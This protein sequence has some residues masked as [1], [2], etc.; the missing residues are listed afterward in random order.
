MRAGYTGNSPLDQSHFPWKSP[1]LHH[2]LRMPK[3]FTFFI[4]LTACVPAFAQAEEPAKTAAAE[5]PSV[6]ACIPKAVSD[7]GPPTTFP[8]KNGLVTAITASSDLAQAETLQGL[9]HL[10]GGWEFEASRHFAMAMK[11]DPL[12]LMAHWGMLL[13]I[14]T[15]NPE[16]DANRSAIIER[17]LQLVSDGEGTELERGYTYGIFKYL[18]EG[19]SGAAEAFRKVANKYPGELQAEIFAALFMRSGYDETG[20][21]TPEQALAEER[22]ATLVKQNPDNPIPLHALLLASAEAPD[23]RPKLPLAENLCELVPDYPP[24][25][26][27]LGHYQWR[28]GE[29]SKAAASFERAATLYAE[30]MKENNVPVADCDGWIRAEAYRAVA[31]ASKGDFENALATAEKIAKTPVDTT[32]PAATGSRQLVWEGKTLPARL[33]MYRGETGDAAKALASLPSTKEMQP[34]LGK[35]LSY[36]WVDGLRIALESQRLLDAQ[37]YAQAADT[38]NAMSVHGEAMTKKQNVSV[39]VGERSEWNR[40]FRSLEIL[41][42]VLRGRMALAGPAEGHGSAFNWFRAATDRQ[43]P[44]SMLTAPPILT[45]MATLL[46]DYYL[47]QNEPSKAVDAYLEALASFPNNIIALQKLEKGYKRLEQNDKAAETAA[48]IAEITSGNP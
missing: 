46:G 35:S 24:Y 27:V 1:T 43:L 17:M 7:L 21:A 9:N 37:N 36:W 48:K 13:T 44:S 40:S 25:Y 26:Q 15:P 33:L 32:R 34:L 2:R 20:D 28:S 19:P 4:F 11:E 29:H 42:A 39:T 5:I 38:I 14:L 47:T 45:P 8:F 18:E 12:C 10:H 3:L 22:L 16:T 41:A 31:L 30:W 6:E 23:L